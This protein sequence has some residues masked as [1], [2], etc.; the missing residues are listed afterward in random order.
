MDRKATIP[1]RSEAQVQR[2]A[3]AI[4]AA[5]GVDMRRTNTRTFTVVGRG[6]KTRPMFCGEPGDPD[7]DG[8]LPDG[9]RVRCEYKHEGWRPGHARGKDLAR[10]MKQ[11][12]KLRRANDM[13][14]VG[15]WVAEPEVLHDVIPK[16]LAGFRVEL[17]EDGNCWVTNE[18]REE[19]SK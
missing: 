9:R 16:L 15:L 10:W 19:A 18:P 7:S 5:Y 8:Q 14:G 4:W 12:A 17:D 3:M 13:N 11:L 1:P 6:G 2:E